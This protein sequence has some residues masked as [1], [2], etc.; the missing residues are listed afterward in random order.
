MPFKRILA[1]VG[2][3]FEFLVDIGMDVV[4]MSE[5]LKLAKNYLMSHGDKRYA[6]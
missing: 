6:V 5:L 2:F 4:G 3:W 1:L